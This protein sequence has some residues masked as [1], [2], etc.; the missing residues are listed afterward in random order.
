ME[1]KRIVFF[2]NSEDLTRDGVLQ[3]Q[4][5]GQAQY[6]RSQ[7]GAC[8]V[9]GFADNAEAA[10]T[11]GDQFRRRYGVEC[12]LFPAPPS[13]G[14]P[15]LSKFRFAKKMLNS[16]LPE[17]ARFH[18][19]HIYT[20]ALQAFGPGRQLA[21]RLGA[22]HVHGVRGAV[23]AECLMH[24]KGDRRRFYY[25]FFRLLERHCIRRAERLSAVSRAMSRWLDE[26]FG[27]GDATVIPCCIGSVAEPPS[28][29]LRLAIREE[30]GF[31]PTQ[32]VLCYCGGTAVWQKLAEIIAL[33]S[34]LAPLMPELRFLFICRERSVV[35]KL[36]AEAGLALDSC[37]IVGG[38]QAEVAR[39]LTAADAGVILREKDLVNAVSCPV[40]VGEYLAAG[41]PLVMSPGIGDLSCLVER[42]GIGV[43]ADSRGDAAKVA[44]FLRADRLPKLSERCREFAGSYFLWRNHHDEMTE[45]FK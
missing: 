41:L 6:I 37:R 13:G 17:L 35:E 42:N 38:N 36:C 4:V 25:H 43:L 32:K 8:L 31:P 39:W 33:M 14:I 30:L 21:R 11:F 26:E 22:V 40:K 16:F 3:S 24:P 19:T 12:R 45:L 2:N 34:A 23:A 27:R 9:V 18:P 7:G 20:R 10:E 29:E 1:G 44:A 5:L 28:A 15:L